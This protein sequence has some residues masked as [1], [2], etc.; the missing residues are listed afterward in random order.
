MNKDFEVAVACGKWRNG[1]IAGRII[2]K[3]VGLIGG[4]VKWGFGGGL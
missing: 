4:G 1:K 3:V 2:D